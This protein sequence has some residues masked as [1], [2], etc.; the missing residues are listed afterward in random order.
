M[1]V[2]RKTLKS[3]ISDRSLTGDRQ[4]RRERQFK[5][6]SSR[7]SGSRADVGDRRMTVLTHDNSE[8]SYDSC[9]KLLTE[10]DDRD[11]LLG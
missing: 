11:A 3:G 1:T 10:L 4:I 5:V 2:R 8:Q 9:L 6:L 7:S